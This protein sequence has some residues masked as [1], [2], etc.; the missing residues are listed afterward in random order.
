MEVLFG[1][2]DHIGDFVF[3]VRDDDDLRPS[4][5]RPARLQVQRS[6]ERVGGVPIEIG[7]IGED[8]ASGDEAP[9]VS[10]QAR[11]R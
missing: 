9:E 1:K 11:V 6:P 10:L 8:G 4:Q 5:G 7:W 2:S 3:V